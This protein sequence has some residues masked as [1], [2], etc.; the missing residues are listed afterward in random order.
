MPNHGKNARRAKAL[1]KSGDAMLSKD[2]IND[3]VTQFKGDLK[4][5]SPRDLARRH[6]IFGDCATI[7]PEVYYRLR[8][9]VAEKYEIHPNEVIVIG[10]G[11]LGFSIAPNKRYR[12]FSHD[13]DLDVVIISERF[14]DKCWSEVFR[15]ESQ[16]GYWGNSIEFKKFLFRG[17]LRPDKLPPDSQFEF[18]RKWWEFFNGLSASRDFSVA[19]IRGAIYRSWEFLETYQCQAIDQCAKELD[20]GDKQ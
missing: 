19:R 15:F 9:C 12:H 8:S 2:E 13:S 20:G 3:H 18:G 5:Y 4:V 10:S 11:K 16:G 7:S 1:W 17:W 14:F 6:V